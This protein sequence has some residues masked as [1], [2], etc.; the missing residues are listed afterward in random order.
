VPEVCDYLFSSWVN[1]KPYYYNRKVL[2]TAFDH[3]DIDFAVFNFTVYPFKNR[4]KA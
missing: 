1:R 3:C 4:E 2:S